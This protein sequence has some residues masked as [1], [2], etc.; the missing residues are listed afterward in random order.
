MLPL[1]PNPSLW[2]PPPA[3]HAHSHFVPS[4]HASN[5]TFT[6]PYASAPLLLTILMLPR[7]PQDKSP[8]LPPHLLP[9]PSLCLIMRILILLSLLSIMGPAGHPSNWRLPPKML[10]CFIVQNRAWK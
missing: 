8:T 6:T 7:R 5:A 10:V 2:L 9:H 1:H 3:Y 4:Q